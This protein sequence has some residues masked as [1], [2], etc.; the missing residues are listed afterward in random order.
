MSSNAIEAAARA[1][2][3][4]GQREGPFKLRRQPFFGDKNRAFWVLQSVGWT[5]YFVLRTLTGVANAFAWSFILHTLL[6]TA[7]GYSMT[8][9][10][11]AVYR[12]LI[13]LK[14]L[15][16]WPVTVL[17]VVVASAGLAAEVAFVESVALV[18][19]ADADADAAFVGAAEGGVDATAVVAGAAAA[20]F[21]G[22]DSAAGAS[23]WSFVAAA[24]T[25]GCTATGALSG[26][27]RILA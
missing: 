19:G 2:V 15:A 10:M 21:T 1:G 12:R 23:A 27:P 14:P 18:T 3:A 4:E 11:A 16:T 25:A 20:L 8:L 6:L 13:K 7:A 17:I 24:D 5:G 9:L 22:A 26:V